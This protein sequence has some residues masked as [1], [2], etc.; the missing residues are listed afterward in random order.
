M[1]IDLSTALHDLVDG[2]RADGPAPVDVPR[3]RSQ[4]RRRRVAHL[5][6]RGAVGVGAAGA[7]ALGAT[8]LAGARD[9][10][11]VLPSDPDAAPGECGSSVAGLGRT[12][13]PTLGLARSSWSD[14]GFQAM[15]SRPDAVP[16]PGDLG[17]YVGRE[18]WVQAVSSR[19]QDGA[20]EPATELSSLQ[21]TLALVEQGYVDRL[22]AREAGEEVSQE[23]LDERAATV[24]GLRASIATRLAA[25]EVAPP[26]PA[27]ARVRVLVTYDEH[28]VATAVLPEEGASDASAAWD[29][30]TSGLLTEQVRLGLVTCTVDGAGGDPLPAGTYDVLV[31]R[32][33]EPLTDASGPWTLTVPPLASAATGLPD[34]FP[35]DVVPMP[36]GTVLSVD[37]DAT[38]GWR[39]E[40]DVAGVDRLLVAADLLTAVDGAT[41]EYRD[42]LGA[43][44]AVPGWSVEIHPGDEGDDTSLFYDVRPR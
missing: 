15:V 24:A 28:V 11:T 34:D 18:V 19:P 21:D 40:L 8:Y 32:E 38:A 9:A 39:V 29:R 43:G 33:G 27:V 13:D 37:G 22:R 23:D 7:M 35:V 30:S 36:P 3:V 4:A 25:G 5:G 44:V 10:R 31:A 6:A 20:G 1:S 26:T 41:E 14:P 16:V 2:R 12:P 42:P 17:T